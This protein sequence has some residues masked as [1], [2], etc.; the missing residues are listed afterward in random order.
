MAPL[1]PPV[2]QTIPQGLLGMLQLK[3][4]GRNPSFL[5]DTVAPQLDLF[6]FYVERTAQQEVGLF[7]AALT[8]AG[9][10]TGAHGTVGFTIAP[11]VPV[12]ETW[13]VTVFTVNVQTIAAADYVRMAPALGI[14]GV[15]AFTVGPDVNDVISARARTVTSPPITKPFWAPPG[16]VFAVQVFDILTATSIAITA[17]LRA[18]RVPI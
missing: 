14:P 8:T 16:S 2:I 15:S 7:G 10:A 17:S 13:W 12:N 11:T 1:P 3:E 18:S 9:L 6:N 4:L 5:A